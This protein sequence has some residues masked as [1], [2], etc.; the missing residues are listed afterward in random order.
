V[1][2]PFA[3]VQPRARGRTALVA[4]G[5][6]WTF[7]ELDARMG[8]FVAALVGAGVAPGDRVA[9]R[10]SNRAE[11]V[12]ALLGMAA[13][14]VTAVLVHPR[15]TAAEAR[16]LIDDAEVR[17]SLDDDGVDAL[18][19]DGVDRPWPALPA[20]TTGDPL[21]MIYTSGT[22]GRAKGAVLTHGAFAASAD[23]SA[24]NLGWAPG[25][26]WVA[27][28]PV[29]H[30][31]GL[32]VLTRCLLAR[33][34]VALLPRFDAAA[35][36]DAVRA[37]GTIVSV[38][39]TMLRALLEADR[40]NAL[41]GARVVLV[42]GAACPAELRG[43][44]RKRRVRA[45]M[46]YGMTE[47]CSQVATQRPTREAA[48]QRGVGRALYGVELRIADDE[49]AALAAGEVGRITVR[50][51]MRMR[52]YWRQAPLA[53]EEWFDTGDLG[54][55][56]AD[57]VLSIHAR[58]TDLIVTGGENV[59]PVEVEHCLEAHPSVAAALVFGLPDEVWGQRV[60]AVVVAR[61]E[62]A[63]EAAW[64][65][66]LA[67]HVAAR[68]A[69]FK[70]PRALARAAAIATLPSGKPDRAGAAARYGAAATA[71]EGVSSRA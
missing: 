8:G 33:R 35:V 28:L 37:G 58:R 13:A 59:Y 66:S 18:L 46:T 15:L 31:G 65:A 11:T 50:G 36:L 2:S 39:P 6:A 45:L 32:S 44:C 40:G 41:A 14:G 62:V 9:L 70:R 47:M 69:G 52:G 56:D 34:P 20:P 25:D 22:S 63:D 16:V 5:R 4:D 55:L 51:P 21:A 7:G 27:A 10:G 19:R 26:R 3:R 54:A 42:G 60:A 48:V 17:A 29:A 23:A 1:S 49:G 30:V 43:E 12:T 38:V 24:R 67:E 61:G 64:R 53:P 57:G 71:W 68:L